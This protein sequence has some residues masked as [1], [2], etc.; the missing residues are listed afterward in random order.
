MVS[1]LPA[2]LRVDQAGLGWFSHFILLNLVFT[3]RRRLVRT[4]FYVGRA[5][6][7]RVEVTHGLERLDW[8]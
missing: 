5:G 1:G 8:V 4:V 2:T 3:L 7:C 6:R